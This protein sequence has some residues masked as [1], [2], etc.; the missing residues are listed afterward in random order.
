[1]PAAIHQP[2]T[3][4]KAPYDTCTPTSTNRTGTA[5]LGANPRDCR[6][7]IRPRS[8]AHL[9]AADHRCSR[10]RN[11][12]LQHCSRTSVGVGMGGISA[13]HV[14]LSSP[15]HVLVE[16]SGDRHVPRLDCWLRAV[17]DV[18][19]GR[20]DAPTHDDLLSG[21]GCDDRSRQRD[22]HDLLPPPQGWLPPIGRRF[23]WTY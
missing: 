16:L 7:H 2:R 18:P 12:H 23:R 15:T 21:M 3:S 19:S 4:G 9:P 10:R 6:R 20:P 8:R 17:V 14:R 5:N 13:L 1:M 11:R 22:C